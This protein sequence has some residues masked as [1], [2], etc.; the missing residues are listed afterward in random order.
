VKVVA[1]AVALV[2]A[3]AGVHG[4]DSDDTPMPASCAQLSVQ[5]L[6]VRDQGGHRTVLVVRP[7]GADSA[8][9]PVVYLLHGFPG[10]PKSVLPSA[11]GLV[12]AACSVGH[13]LVVAVPDGSLGDLD[14]EWGDNPAYRLDDETFV[15]RAAVA[16]VEGTHRRSAAN[17]I[18]AGFSMGG[19]GAAALGLRHP[20][21]YARVLSVAGYFH[22]DD[23]AHVFGTDPA[24][25]GQHSPDQLIR[26]SSGQRFF[27]V[28]GAQDPLGLVRP[29]TPRFTRL[30]VEAGVPVQSYR[31]PGGHTL[32]VL[33]AVRG[34][35]LRFLA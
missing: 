34:P 29:E 19:F 12:Q 6:H 24:G 10:W 18:I 33:G 30:L 35:L 5:T 17:R 7:P 25:Q 27:L 14:T 4:A 9:I 1:F 22:L 23:P 20:D 21:L 16:V 32:A 3:V 15:T 28:D 11:E 13:R 8:A 26:P 31:P 2:T